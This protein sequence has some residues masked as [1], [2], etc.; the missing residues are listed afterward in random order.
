MVARTIV[1]EAAMTRSPRPPTDSDRQTAVDKA[2]SLLATLAE[3][4]GGLGVSELAR[5]TRLTK[6]TAF[7]LLGTL[8]RNDAV[9]R[10]GSNYRLG[11]K[12]QYIG[13]RV[14]GPTIVL[15][16]ETLL[17]FLADLYELTHETVHL[18]VLHDTETLYVNKIHGH[19]APRSPS[20]TGICLPA[21]CTG[22]GKALL[23]F[24]HDAT[25]RAVERGLT[26]RTPYS[27]TAPELLRAELRR[28]RQ[29]GI[30]HDHQEAALGLSCVAAPIMGAAGRPVAALSVAGADRS[31]EPARFAPALRRVA[32]D[33][34]RTLAARGN[35]PRTL[36][37]Y[38]G[39]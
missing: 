14:Y 8:Q 6:S 11:T 12:M 25:E 38:L 18:A 9:E 5:R 1:P 16:R 22:V 23:A 36:P 2:L 31:F 4:D 3:Q 30:A 34:A 33:A 19:R 20:Q 29:D 21:H 24:D 26:G 32:F 15:L 28:I 10:V 39:G 17:P 27:L 13:A 35:R 37:N 7:R